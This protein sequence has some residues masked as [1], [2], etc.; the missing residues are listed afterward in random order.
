M[1]PF[2]ILAGAGIAALF[3]ADGEMEEQ[4][5]FVREIAKETE[6]VLQVDNLEVENLAVEEL[7]TEEVK[8]E[9]VQVERQVEIVEPES[10]EEMPELE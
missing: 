1:I 8:A 7:K 6:I 4:K 5:E 3:V 2:L 9:E 10:A